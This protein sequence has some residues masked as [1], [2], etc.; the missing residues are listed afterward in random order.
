MNKL[1]SALLCS[2]LMVGFAPCAPT[3]GVQAATAM[4]A[5]PRTGTG[6]PTTSGDPVPLR[7]TTDPQVG[8]PVL[9]GSPAG[10]LL[11]D[12]YAVMEKLSTVHSQVTSLEGSTRLTV[13][14]DCGPTGWHMQIGGE[15][16]T[17]SPLAV[18]LADLAQ[19]SL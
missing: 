9:G 5:L 4:C 8:R 17:A 11:L 10:T 6:A 3:I 1:L 15:D 13:T 7:V 16:T 12:S 19:A 2:A 18:T 14:G